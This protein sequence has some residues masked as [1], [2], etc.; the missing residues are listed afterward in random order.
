MDNTVIFLNVDHVLAT[1][2][3][4]NYIISFNSHSN[5]ATGIL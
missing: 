3:G 5:S 2:K 4:F 1:I